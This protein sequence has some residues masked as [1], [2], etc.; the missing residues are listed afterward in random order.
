MKKLLISL[1]VIGV[2]AFMIYSF[3]VGRYN[4]MVQLDQD[5]K[6]ARS[7]VE[8]QYQRRLDL[9]PNLVSTVQWAANFEKSTLQAVIEARSKATQTNVNVNDAEGF[10]KFQE[11][12]WELSSALSR[13]MVVVEQYPDLKANKNFLELQSQLEWTENRITVERKRYN[14]TVNIYN[15]YIKMFPSN[16]IAGFFKFMEAQLFKA[17][18]LAN[19]APDVNFEAK[20]T[21]SQKT[22]EDL[23]AQ[24]EA[25]KLKV[26]LEKTKQELNAVKGNTTTTWTN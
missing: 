24:L 2:I 5:V 26:E 21:D 19:K 1:W 18:E 10:A 8:N 20:Q 14:D 7:Q 15:K 11:S 3:V 4:S 12:Q 22:V 6:T 17:E 16:V 13:L 25:E 23:K 9:I